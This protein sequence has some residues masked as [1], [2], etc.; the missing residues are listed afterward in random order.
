MVTEMI[1]NM[2]MLPFFFKVNIRKKTI[3]NNDILDL[4]PAVSIITL[5]IRLNVPIKGGDYQDL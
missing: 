5:N 3:K 4:N 2:V 1:Q